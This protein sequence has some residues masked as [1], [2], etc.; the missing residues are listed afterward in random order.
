ML[1]NMVIFSSI[2][3]DIIGSRFQYENHR[4]EFFDLLDKSCHFTDDSVIMLSIVEILNSKNKD[5]FFKNDHQ[6]E[7]KNYISD[8]LRAWCCCFLNRKFS[9]NFFLWITEGI[10]EPYYSKGNNPL[11]RIAPIFYWCKKNNIST[12]QMKN[13][14]HLWTEITH[15]HEDNELWINF[16]I[17]LLLLLEE[18]QHLNI[19]GKKNIIINY[20]KNYQFFIHSIEQLKID[21]AFTFDM[22]KTLEIAIS[23][24]LEAENYEEVFYK[25]VSVGG[26]SDTYCVI[27]G[28]LASFLW[29]FPI[30]YR[31]KIE[32]FFRLEEKDLLKN[33][34]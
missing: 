24:N 2:L 10:N 17:D 28:V 14:I 32:S 12:S 11:I 23:A 30:Q 8:E 6:E 31:E 21:S 27:A 16:Y 1:F 4:S 25:T 13:L 33:I 15:H 9:P 26:V 29:K 7:I 19:S 3:G 20:L 34:D 18:N 22:K 5:F